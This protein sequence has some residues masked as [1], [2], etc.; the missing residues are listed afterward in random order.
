MSYNLELFGQKLRAIRKSLHISKSEIENKA[1]ISSKTI[2]R[3]ENAKSLPCLDTLELL[4]PLYKTDLVS[5]L[6]E[7]R[8][9]NYSA[10][11]SIS[12][13]IESKIDNLE[14]DKLDIN[15][16]MLEKL[17]DSTNNRHYRNYVLQLRLLINGMLLYKN[18][19]YT[20]ALDAYIEALKITEPNFSLDNY[21]NLVLSTAEIRILMNIGFAISKIEGNKKSLD[22]M[23]FCEDSLDKTDDLYSK[24]CHNIAVIYS[25]MENYQKALEYYNNG[26]AA[27]R[28]C[29]LPL[30]LGLLYYG[31]GYSEYKLNYEGYLDS[32]N[33]SITLCVA[34]GQDK[35]KETIIS[36]CKEHCNINL[37][38]AETSS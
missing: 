1:R 24:I 9:D 20:S 13:E 5:L 11:V 22:I 28:K 15:L 34:F 35:L 18:D 25:K 21:Q 4:S 3:L 8:F 16:N 31:K 2:V 19:N 32:L 33:I 37:K 36:N 38:Q 26:I 23:L 17:E 10:F 7:C 29:R 6:L 12:N 30:G 27:C 14:F